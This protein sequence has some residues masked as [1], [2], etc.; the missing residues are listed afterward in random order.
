MSPSAQNLAFLVLLAFLTFLRAPS[1]LENWKLQGAAAAPLDTYE[2]ISGARQELRPPYVLVFWATWC[3]PCRLELSRIQKLVDA[4]MI[5][6]RRVHAVATD[7]AP[8]TVR[9]TAR[10]RG[11]AFPI[12]LDKSLALS[13]RYPVRATPTIVLV[14]AEG[15]LNWVTTGLSA[16]LELRLLSVL[17]S[18]PGR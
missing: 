17:S 11:Y 1:A 4:G 10:L 8:E 12:A 6:G 7:E 9:E 5:D 18:V 2:D 3:A 16:T 13:A 14:D 15:K